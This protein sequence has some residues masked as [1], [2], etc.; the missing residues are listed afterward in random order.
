M[1]ACVSVLDCGKVKHYKLKKLD[2]G[3]VF[4]SRARAFLTVQ[5]LVA[6]YSQEADGLCVRL[7]EPCRK[8]NTSSQI[9]SSLVFFLKFTFEY[10]MKSW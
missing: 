9:L 1:L 8:V 5:E 10:S 7:G 2:N 6:H 4:V 3:H